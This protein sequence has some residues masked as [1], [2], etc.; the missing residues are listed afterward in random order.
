MR[1]ASGSWRRWLAL[2]ASLWPHKAVA[3]AVNVK[4]CA[5][6]LVASPNGASTASGSGRK[7]AVTPGSDYGGF[8]MRSV[9]A[10]SVPFWRASASR[11][12]VMTSTPH[13]LPKHIMSLQSHEGQ[14]AGVAQSVCQRVSP[15][16]PSIAEDRSS[17][18]SVSTL[19]VRSDVRSDL[20]P[21][22]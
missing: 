13:L 20:T 22:M 14:R 11:S 12:G 6:R 10:V 4:V 2:S 18:L 16:T 8:D 5:C 1:P 21:H 7:M 19:L 15:V 3:T 9:A 17:S